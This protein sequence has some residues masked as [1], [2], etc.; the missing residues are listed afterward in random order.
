MRLKEH[1][2][3]VHSCIF[4]P[5]GSITSPSINLRCIVNCNTS[6][7]IPILLI[8]FRVFF[9]I[10]SAMLC[11]PILSKLFIIDKKITSQLAG[12]IAASSVFNKNSYWNT[13]ITS[14]LFSH[15]FAFFCSVISMLRF[16]LSSTRKS[17]QS[18]SIIL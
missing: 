17:H 16:I 1:C 2:Y 7:S 11:P 15:H 18:G 12:N 13:F 3:K 14:Y 6:G 10:V 8:I 4:R 9:E 5:F